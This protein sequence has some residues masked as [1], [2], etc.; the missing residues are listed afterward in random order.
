MLRLVSLVRTEVSEERLASIVR[1]TRIGE[2]ACFR[3]LVTA[4]DVPSFLVALN[5]KAKLSSEM[6]VLTRATRL[7][8]PEDGNLHSHRDANLKSSL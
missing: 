5:M 4:N 6:S 8:N 3:L 1:V 7:N 2:A